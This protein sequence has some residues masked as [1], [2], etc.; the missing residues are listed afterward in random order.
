M[1]RFI[2]RPFCYPRGANK[3]TQTPMRQMNAPIQSYRSGV[4][5]S[6]SHPHRTA[7]TMNTPPYAAYTRP[8]EGRIETSEECHR[9]SGQALRRS[10]SRLALLLSATAKLNT[11]R[12]FRQ[13][14]PQEIIE[15]KS[16]SRAL[17]N[18]H[19]SIIIK[20]ECC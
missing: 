15:W 3:I 11:R 2:S 13:A 5:R 8:K 1:A 19:F 6:T 10:H 7:S 20:E 18:L 14:P 4:F 17:L 16:A 12:Q 9:Q